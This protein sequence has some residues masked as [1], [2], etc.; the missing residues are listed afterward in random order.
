[1]RHFRTP[2]LASTSQRHSNLT[3]L[4]L[5]TLLLSITLYFFLLDSYQRHL[6]AARAEQRIE[7]KLRNVIHDTAQTLAAINQWDD[8]EH[9]RHYLRATLHDEEVAAWHL[10]R[11]GQDLR[12]ARYPLRDSDWLQMT[13]DPQSRGWRLKEVRLSQ[14]DSNLTGTLRLWGNTREEARG[15]S[16]WILYLPLLLGWCAVLILSQVPRWLRDPLQQL[17]QV[18]EQQGNAL[19][20]QQRLLA[21]QDHY[22][23]GDLATSILRSKLETQR[24]F[25]FL[26][27]LNRAAQ[28]FATAPAQ[29]QVFEEL[30]RAIRELLPISHGSIFLRDEQTER[31][32]LV[33]T[34]PDVELSSEAVPSFQVGEGV[35]GLVAQTRRAIFVPDITEDMRFH[36]ELGAAEV[37]RAVMCVPIL[38]D[39]ESDLLGVLNLSAPVGHLEY[40]VEDRQFLLALSRLAGA[41]L[42]HLQL[43]SIIEY[44]NQNLSRMVEERTAELRRE[45]EHS[46]LL[47]DVAQQARN[48]IQELLDYS[49]E[50]FLSFGADFLIFPEYSRFCETL[51]GEKLA[52]KNVLEVVFGN[53]SLQESEAKTSSSLQ[54]EVRQALELVFLGRSK[55]RKLVAILP[56][57]VR[58]GERTLQ[59]DYKYIKRR[60]RMMLI[61]SDVTQE[62]LLAQQVATEEERNQMIVRVATD[63]EMFTEFVLEQ[64][65]LFLLLERLTQQSLAQED[66]L[67]KLM[68]HFHTIKGGAANYGLMDVSRQAHEIEHYLTEWR[69][70]GVPSEAKSRLSNDLQQLKQRY[71]AYLDELKVLFPDDQSD[72][73]LRIRES[74]LWEWQKVVEQRLLQESLAFLKSQTAS[75]RSRIA[76]ELLDKY[77][78]HHQ[79]KTREFQQAVDCL[80]WQPIGPVL[81]RLG[82]AAQELAK[83]LNKEVEVVIE[84]GDVEIPLSRYR[85]VFNNL[86]HLVRNCI[87][88]GLEQDPM[89]RELNEKPR[90]G[91]LIFHAS[92]ER[93]ALL[94]R[95]QDDGQGIDPERVGQIALQ[96]GLVDEAFLEHATTREVQELIFR[97][98]FST[99]AEVSDVSGRGVGMDAVLSALHEN[100]G[101]LVIDSQVGVGTTFWIR[102]PLEN[103]FRTHL[104]PSQ[105]A[106]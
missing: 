34:D 36:Q 90:V 13:A 101:S 104:R 39:T 82:T 52:G 26:A 77:Q 31:F 56:E 14:I 99:K 32:V 79:L 93:G 106:A 69:A 61:I 74:R 59:L 1:M 11:N 42:K 75:M 68:R 45:K 97:A 37:S 64:N 5:W 47:A 9:L 41:R 102:V 8:T 95:I 20:E 87:D 89:M 38:Q 92:E 58:L 84:G 66:L 16:L 17:Q 98:G 78:E 105:V 3:R 50:G 12:V 35:S 63:R 70:T 6:E 28:A 21:L 88:H 80:A 48:T 43:L 29:R 53:L 54:E 71:Q 44:H 65:Q 2:W 86:I 4:L 23:I 60:C 49:G 30:I 96:K 18:S 40:R 7:T 25:R 62:N 46:E 73:S 22:E 81:R 85:T 15:T 76:Q 94:L 19:W 24:K 91:K 72:H 10:S 33:H 83:R 51:F 103:S 57:D 100:Q 67:G 55:L 27:E